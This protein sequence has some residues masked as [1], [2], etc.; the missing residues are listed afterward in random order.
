MDHHD[1]RA[2][3]TDIN[4]MLR[5]ARKSKRTEDWNIYKRLRSVCNNKL[6]TAKSAFQRDLL[7][8]NSFNPRKFWR[9]IKKILL[10]RKTVTASDGNSS[11]KAN[12]RKQAEELSEYF[13]LAVNKLKKKSIRLMDFIWNYSK[14]LATGASNDFKLQNVSN[15]FVLRELRKLN[16]NKDYRPI[17]VLPSLS[18]ILEKA[19]HQ[20]LMDH[21]SF[22]RAKI[23]HGISV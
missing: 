18:K 20:Q 2:S 6:K 22:R 13:A 15:A 9:V 16:R 11:D 21:R 7:D 19:I 8:Q 23:T 12:L 14:R 10:F 1:L 17:S 3:M 4:R 5:K